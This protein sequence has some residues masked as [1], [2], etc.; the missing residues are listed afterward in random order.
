MHTDEQYIFN[1][2]LLGT[3][4]PGKYNIS[5]QG[6]CGYNKPVSNDYSYGLSSYIIYNKN[7]K[8]EG[9]GGYGEGNVPAAVIQDIIVSNINIDISPGIS[10]Y[11]QCDG[12]IIITPIN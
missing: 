7:Q 4:E 11:K 3:I 1:K 10:S 6:A 5:V 8:L 9:K 2:K 12:K